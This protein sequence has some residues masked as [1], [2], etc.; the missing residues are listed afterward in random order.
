MCNLCN[1]SEVFYTENCNLEKSLNKE[2]GNAQQGL[3]WEGPL[4]KEGFSKEVEYDPKV[5]YQ[6]LLD[7]TENLSN[8]HINLV[9]QARLNLYHGLFK[10]SNEKDIK[11]I[12]TNKKYDVTKGDVFQIRGYDLASMTIVYDGTGWIVM[13]VLTTSERAEAAWRNI[14]VAFFETAVINTVIYSHSHIDHYGG[15]G[16][17]KKYF[18]KNYVILAPEG[19]TKHAVSENVYVGTA[20]TRRAMYQYG[21]NLLANAEGRVDCGLGKEVSKGT[22]TILIPTKELGFDDYI[23]GKKYCVYDATTRRIINPEELQ[24][25]ELTTD[26][27]LHIQYTPGTEAPAE[28][29]VYLPSQ[30]ILFIAE[31]CA[32]TLH[33]TLT[34]RG[35]EVRDP[36]A[37]AS[38]LDETLVTFYDL[39]IVCNAHNQPHFGHEESMRF[40]EIQRDMYRY[41]NN[42]TLHLVNLGY[43]IDEVGRMLSGEDG[44]MPLPKEFAEEWCCHGFYG[45]YNHDAKAVYQRYIGWY[46]GNPTHLNPHKPT[47]RATRYVIAFGADSLLEKATVALKEKDYV[48]ASELYDYLLTAEST[49]ITE[50]QFAYVKKGYAEALRQMGIASESPSWRN[51]YLTGASEVMAYSRNGNANRRTPSYLMFADD[52]VEA[53]SLEMILQ[54]LGIMLDSRQVTRDRFNLTISIEVDGEYANGTINHGVFD[55]RIV[56]SKETLNKTAKIN[57]RG[58]KLS[59]FRV[60]V[61]HDMVEINTIVSDISEQGEAEKF[62]NNYLKRFEL[63]FPIMTPR[64]KY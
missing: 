10:V 5:T 19:F 42:A 58:E 21:T 33:N 27:L 59:F 45:T 40:I 2:K 11:K 41:I 8:I 56:H 25:T 36:L 6:F 39:E 28:M 53:M 43:T 24:Q 37:W 51:M 20:M 15:I 4:L 23:S 14:V 7:D 17:L 60:F 52:T 54:Y 22:N 34:P 48:W 50:Q 47:D 18:H 55:Y 13:D 61:D 63:G 30:K 49:Y 31:N 29:N 12:D 46:D 44:T 35:A 38:F 32:G 57:I 62:V 16:G 64:M 1:K 26:M 3:L 9:E